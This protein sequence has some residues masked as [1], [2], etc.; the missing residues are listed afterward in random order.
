[1]LGYIDLVVIVG[2]EPSA[3]HAVQVRPSAVDAST[4]SV[5][6]TD[7]SA[8]YLFLFLAALILAACA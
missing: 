1:L 6:S 2:G 5:Q 3:C 7:Q 8:H 4:D